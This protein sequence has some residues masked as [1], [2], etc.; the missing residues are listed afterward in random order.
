MYNAVFQ[1]LVQDKPDF[2]I[3]IYLVFSVNS[4]ILLTQPFLFFS[5]VHFL[6]SFIFY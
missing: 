5:Q 1:E 6:E 3:I 2:G 4:R